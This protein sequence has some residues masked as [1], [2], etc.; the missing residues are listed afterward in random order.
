MPKTDTDNHDDNTYIPTPEKADKS[1][2]V[3]K[4]FYLVPIVL[5]AVLAGFTIFLLTRQTKINDQDPIG[6]SQ[7]FTLETVKQ[8]ATTDNC[9]VIIGQRVYNI[10]PI[11]N[12]ETYGLTQYCGNIFPTEQISAKDIQKF[13]SLIEPHMLGVLAP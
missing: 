7:E 6:E 2:N 13:N 1:R 12:N 10:T 8:H 9:W 4:L 11:A 5:I 3:S